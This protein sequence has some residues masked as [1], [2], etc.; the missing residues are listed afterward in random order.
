MSPSMPAAISAYSD[1]FRLP[2]CI[3]HRYAAMILPAGSLPFGTGNSM[4]LPSTYG[5][6]GPPISV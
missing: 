5:T 3:G 6:Q 1:G 2:S 4:H